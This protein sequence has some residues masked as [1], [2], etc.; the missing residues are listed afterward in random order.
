MD[1]GVLGFDPLGVVGFVELFK[2]VVGRGI[3]GG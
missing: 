3:G 2:V 1:L